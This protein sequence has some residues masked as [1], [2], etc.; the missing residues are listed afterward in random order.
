M[1]ERMIFGLPRP[2]NPV[3][4]A[5]EA[6]R[7]HFIGVALFSALMNL[8]ILV[9]LLYMLPIY[10]RVV[11][12]RGL[13]TL[14]FL[15]LV[16]LFAL[17]TSAILDL[18]RTRLLVRASI[19]LDRLL[20]GPTLET[21]L[22]QRAGSAQGRQAMREFDTLRQTLGGPALVA[23]CDLPWSP[24]FVLICFL[25]HPARGLLVTVGGAV[26]VVVTLLNQRATTHRLREANEAASRSYARQEE[27]LLHSDTVRALGMR[28]AMVGRNVADR[29]SMIQ[30][31]SEA[32]FAGGRYVT[33]SKFI[34][35]SLQSLALGLGAWLAV[36]DQISVGAIFAASFLAGRALQPVDQMLASW[37]GLSRGFQAYAQINSLLGA[38]PTD[39]AITALPD[40]KGRITVDKIAVARPN[41]QVPIL[42]GVSFEVQ[43]G[44][45]L[46]IA[47]PSGAGKSTLLRALTGLERPL[48]GSIVIDGAGPPQLDDRRPRFGVTF[49]QGALFGS[50][51]VGQNLALPLE[52]WTSL[53]ADAIRAIVRAKLRLVGLADAED[54]LPS[55]L[56][57]GMRKRAAIARA[58]ALEPSLL[59]LDEP[60]SGLDPITSAEIDRLIATLAHVHGLTVVVVT[61]ELGSID[62]IVDRCIL[63]DREHRCILAAGAPR[64][65]HASPHA[66]VRHFF[67]RT[68]EAA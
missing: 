55:T 31:Q 17:A 5:L 68:P 51:T 39:I 13:T 32:G 58:L 6:C 34:R 8:L 10:D 62:A 15:T 25:I 1:I 66:S 61:H 14:V 54:Q 38:R 22:M 29:Q 16:L 63:L 46:A 3:A 21:A 23:L 35:M 27:I 64:D 40:P 19:R 36:G 41:S 59:F 42:A 52:R 11:P 7:R 33:M 28:Q 18:V 65:L 45:V 47:G 57:G 2:S 26:L 49:Q 30:L 67:A 50:M 48:A 60:S 37:A 43:P 53:P 9:P 12:T 4:V 44:E 56:S 20:A 24:L